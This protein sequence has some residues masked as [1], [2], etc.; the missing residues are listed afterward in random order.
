MPGPGLYWFGDEEK[1]HVMDVLAV[2]HL[3]RYGNLDDPKFTRKVF[4]LEREF[5]KYIGVPHA[6]ATS[7]GTSALICCLQA[8]GLKPGDE[9]IV[10]AYT[11][12]GTY[13]AAAFLGLTPVLCDIDESLDIDPVDIERR[14]T[15]KTRAIMAVHMLGNACDMDAIMAIAAKHRLVVIEDACQ[16]AGASYRGRKVGS[17][18]DLGAFS[19]NVY[20]TITAGDGGLVTAR[21]EE[22][23]KLAFG[24]HDQGHS[25]LRAGVEVGSRCMLGL[26]FRMNEITGAIALGQFRKIDR[27]IAALREKKRKFKE[28][29][30]EIPGAHFRKLNDASGECGTLLTVLFDDPARAAN[31]ASSLGTKTVDKSGWHVY[32]NMEHVERFLKE[33]GLPHGKGAYP[34]TDDILLRAINLSVGVVDAGLGAAFGVNINSA[35]AEITEAA[36]RFRA[37]CEASAKQAA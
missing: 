17:I 25:P 27:I 20:K 11:F 23:Y 33:H 16:A 29:I 30:G 32:A 13:S 10:P 4:T 15:P 24:A 6:L 18:G 22:H 37:A 1:Q 12:V 34:R 2:G 35:D 3:S 28:Q 31:V 14:I 19:L 8:A 9:V 7:S 5:A 26:N 36:K 21:T